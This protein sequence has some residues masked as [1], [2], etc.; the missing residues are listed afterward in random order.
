MLHYICLM[1]K[2][3]VFIKS[4]SKTQCGATQLLQKKRVQRD[5]LRAP[6]KPQ[7]NE[8]DAENMMEIWHLCLCLVLIAGKLQS[9]HRSTQ[10]STPAHSVREAVWSVWL[11]H[12]GQHSCWSELFVMI[13]FKLCLFALSWTWYL[14]VECLNDEQVEWLCRWKVMAS[15]SGKL[16]QAGEFGGRI[17]SGSGRYT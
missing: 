10:I 3:Q 4:V 2:S 8:N 9:P 14:Q 6:V 1:H 5:Y 12:K 13:W 7:T 16:V 11:W 17:S 15:G